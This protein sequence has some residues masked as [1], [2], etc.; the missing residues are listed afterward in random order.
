M[1]ND[2]MKRILALL[3]LLALAGCSAGPAN[4]SAGG[5]ISLKVVNAASFDPYADHGR[6]EK[7]RVTV[8]GEGIETPIVAEFAG[9]VK[10]G[11]VGDIPTGEERTVAV[12][13]LNPNEVAIREGEALDVNVGDGV[14]EVSIG[15]EAVP[16]FTN[17]A[18]EN[19]IDN[20]R[21]VF[22]IFSDPANPVMVKEYSDSVD[23]F[24]S[25]A[26]TSLSE[27]YLDQS[28][29]LGRFAPALMD[30]GARIFSAVDMV[31][32]RSH[33]VDVTVVDG[34]SRRPA[35]IVTT[36]DVDRMSQSCSA[37]WCAL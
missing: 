3:A 19:T 23:R 21:L 22:K 13:A 7:Y 5:A 29:G 14:T 6:I 15:M 33:E 32:G 24:L 2:E 28:T 26:S 17:I 8:N 4:E 30:P 20:T 31:T 25:D 27:I 35:P 36:T 1:T 18:D 16:I 34:T 37:P 11:T 12:E 9:D 10:E